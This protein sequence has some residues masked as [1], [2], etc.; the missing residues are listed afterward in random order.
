MYRNQEYIYIKLFGN[1]GDF[2]R[3]QKEKCIK[4]RVR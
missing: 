3:K 4:E 1:A 2:E